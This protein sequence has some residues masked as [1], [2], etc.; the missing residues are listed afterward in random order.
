MMVHGDFSV[1][2]Y[3]TK[4]YSPNFIA[5]LEQE[6]IPI[7]KKGTLTKGLLSRIA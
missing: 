6:L 7:E 3:N 4:Q 2:N 5:L 1:E